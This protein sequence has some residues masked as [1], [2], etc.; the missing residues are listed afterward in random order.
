MAKQLITLVIK[1]NHLRISRKSCLTLLTICRFLPSNRWIFCSQH[2]KRSWPSRCGRIQGEPHGRPWRAPFCN[3]SSRWWKRHRSG[4]WEV[5]GMGLVGGQG[6]MDGSW[7]RVGWFHLWFDGFIQWSNYGLMVGRFDRF[8][9]FFF[10]LSGWW[11]WGLCFS[12][13]SGVFNHHLNHDNN[14]NDG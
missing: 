3:R 9:F 1:D 7:I 13:G 10:F 5:E 11:C 6:L 12:D 4:G 2:R 8:H 14:T